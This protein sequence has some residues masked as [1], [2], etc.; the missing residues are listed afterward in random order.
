M[1]HLALSYLMART[2]RICFGLAVVA[3]ASAFVTSARANEDELEIR[4]RGLL[5][6]HVFNCGCTTEFLEQHFNAEQAEILLQLWV[7]AV[8]DEGSNRETTVLYARHG[9]K[10]IDDTVMKF[11]AQ[12][13]RLRLY[14]A[15]GG[16]PDVTD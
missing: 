15:Q 8:N 1:S 13:D 4:C 3:A 12:R 6:R 7:L 14:C 10:A 11:H 2:K 9:R 5:Q 16:A